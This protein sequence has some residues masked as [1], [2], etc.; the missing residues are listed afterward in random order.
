MPPP[1]NTLRN[2]LL[3]IQVKKIP[4]KK[5]LLLL[6][7]TKH[8]KTQWKTKFLALNH[9][10]PDNVSNPIEQKDVNLNSNISEMPCV[11]KRHYDALQSMMIFLKSHE[12][13]M[14][15]FSK[16]SQNILK[17]SRKLCV[18]LGFVPMKSGQK[19]ENRQKAWAF[20]GKRQNLRQTA[21]STVSVFN[22][23]IMA[24]S[25]MN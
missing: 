25:E 11:A 19:S 17:H 14:T 9:R 18:F 13:D 12:E 6:Y 7:W 16:Q 4:T 23:I 15:R 5:I 20:L 1:R 22:A 3:V 8:I 21:K 10:S 2:T 24:N